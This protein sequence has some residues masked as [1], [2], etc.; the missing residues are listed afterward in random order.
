M[1]APNV[2]VLTTVPRNR[3]PTSGMCGLAIALIVARAA[4]ADGPVGGADVDRAV[5]LDGDLGAGVLLDRVDH[6]ALGADDLAD[7]VHRDLDRDDPRRLGAHL[8][9]GVDRLAHDLQDRE[10][11]PAGLAQRGAEHGGRDPVQLGVELERGDDV[12][13]A[14]DL[15]VHV[16]ERVLGAQDVGE[17]DVL[18]ALVDQAHRDAGHH[19]PQRDARV[20]QRHGGRAHR[21]HRGRA[22]GPDGLGHLADRVRELLAASAAPGSMARSA[23]APWPISRR[24]GEPTRPV[25]P[26]EYGGML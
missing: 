2:V 20:E 14:G 15:E 6:L 25:S 19:V 3:S 13:G 7:L 23:S 26:V 9:R 22:V 1:N 17:R 11:G 5:V 8:A 10:P 18:A 4:S 12:L 24:L 21:A 16:A